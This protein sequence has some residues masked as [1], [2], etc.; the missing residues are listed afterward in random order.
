M[1]LKLSLLIALIWAGIYLP[2]LGV[3]EI[4]CNESRRIFP[5]LTMI[6]SG[7]WTVP[8]LEGQQ[9]FKKPPMINW[10]IASS[11]LVFGQNEF[12]AR[13]PS[14][15]C[16]LLFALAL[17]C[18]D[19]SVIDI[20]TRA[21]SS[22]IFLS[23]FGVLS[24][25]LI[26]EIEAAYISFTG[27]AIVCWLALSS[28]DSGRFALWLLPAIPLGISLLIK[29]PLSLLFFYATVIGVL[30][31]QKKLKR[32]LTF[33][34][35][36]GILLCLGIFFLW[37]HKILLV[38]SP[39][40]ASAATTWWS[41]LK[42]QLESGKFGISLWLKRVA[43][44]I[45]NFA[46][47]IIFC[48][49]MLK[50]SRLLKDQRQ[51]EIFRGMLVS[52]IVCLLL[53]NLMPGTK[54]RYSMP[55][56]PCASLMAGMLI[57]GISQ[58]SAILKIWKTANFALFILLAFVLSLIAVIAAFGRFCA[59]SV[60]ELLTAPLIG[61][62]MQ[63]FRETSGIFYFV[64]LV[65]AA[66]AVL[67]AVSLRKSQPKTALE[68]NSPLDL[69]TTFCLLLVHCSI[70]FSVTGPFV[71]LFEEQKKTAQALDRQLEDGGKVLACRVGVEP[72]FFYLR[73]PYVKSNGIDGAEH[74][75]LILCKNRD[76][77]E[78]EGAGEL[79]AVLHFTLSSDE[80]TA[81]RK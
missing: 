63:A 80:Y 69:A 32:L 47:W 7:D 35:L 77:D 14:A 37:A 59:V 5:A 75:D 6:E 27:I 40:S 78:I 19:S 4:T 42:L 60:P 26:C 24:K 8:V 21:L 10:M 48:P 73:S 15:V 38:D 9:Y 65:L 62:P 56:L 34:H 31:S 28:K 49:L 16:I 17:V 71:E 51:L 46:P 50:P 2:P 45:A 66:S 67:F 30:A 23:S 61:E 18:F 33:G 70:A 22:L 53:I 68:E 12:A 79:D 29:G 57:A 81:F 41:E 1:K 74:G 55:L 52:C 13:L 43:G 54:A 11:I 36:L 76:L 44:S 58:S 72:L 20:R 64:C 25:G 3:C 39:K